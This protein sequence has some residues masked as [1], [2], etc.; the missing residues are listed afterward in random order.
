MTRLLGKYFSVLVSYQ[1]IFSLI[2]L[3]LVSGCVSEYGKPTKSK[4]VVPLTDLLKDPV[5]WEGKVVQIDGVFNFELEGDAIF[6]SAKDY[7]THN[8]NM[9][10]SLNLDDPNLAIPYGQHNNYNYWRK[11]IV[12][13]SLRLHN[14]K[15]ASVVGVFRAKSH[16]NLY[17]GQIDVE[18]L[19]LN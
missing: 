15:T 3:V 12:P 17:I 2:V 10:I 18:C 6:A 11:F 4:V 9:A 1:I 19:I 16:G 14:G 7:K 13:L 8:L 5:K